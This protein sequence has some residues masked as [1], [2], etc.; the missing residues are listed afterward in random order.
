MHISSFF[1]LLFLSPQPS[2]SL[3]TS[4]ILLGLP[5]F[6]V[7]YHPEGPR[8]HQKFETCHVTQV[9]KERGEYVDLSAV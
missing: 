8:Q 7:P 5:T 6:P 2:A 1:I 4:V 9:M 3:F